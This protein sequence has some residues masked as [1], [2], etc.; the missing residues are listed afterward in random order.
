M[1]ISYRHKLTR[2]IGDNGRTDYT[3]RNNKKLFT[4]Q[5]VE[6]TN[7][8]TDRFH[9]YF[10]SDATVRATHN[11]PSLTAGTICFQSSF[12]ERATFPHHVLRDCE[13]ERGVLMHNKV[14]DFTQENSR[15][16]QEV[17][18]LNQLIYVTPST[19]IQLQNKTK[20][21]GWAYVGSANLSESAWGRLVKDR[22]TK[23]P[24][25]NC[26]NWECGVIVPVTSECTDADTDAKD[27]HDESQR[28]EP[29]GIEGT[30][31]AQFARDIF[32]GAVPVPMKT[33]A[34]KISPPSDRGRPGYRKPWFFMG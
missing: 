28:R 22:E 31:E 33:P 27:T 21:K 10:P 29:T 14:R 30:T 32:S 11:N 17:T 7:E 16:D 6:S 34:K 18:N 1:S 13:G 15:L 25:L 3:L 9:V 24:R 20:C 5:M 19:P 8:W 26:R 23:Q 4:S 2:D 12:W